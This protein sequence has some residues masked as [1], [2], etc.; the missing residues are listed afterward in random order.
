MD[1]RDWFKTARTAR[2]AIGECLQAV[3]QAVCGMFA[4]GYD[5]VAWPESGKFRLSLKQ[6][7]KLLCGNYNPG[8]AP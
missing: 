4:A 5:R 8:D 7:R 1:Q 2:Q 6:R 3:R